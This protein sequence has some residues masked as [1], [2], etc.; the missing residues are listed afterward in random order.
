MNK[1]TTYPDVEPLSQAW[2]FAEFDEL[3]DTVGGKEY[4]VYEKIVGQSKPKRLI[5]GY[6][7]FEENVVDVKL[8]VDA[9]NE[10]RFLVELGGKCNAHSLSNAQNLYGKQMKHILNI[11]YPTLESFITGS[12]INTNNN[13]NNNNK[14]WWTDT[15]HSD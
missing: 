5:S 6:C 8:I 12:Y 14:D 9:L 15:D 1:T 10:K 11:Y 7:E 2:Y 3:P 13:N 4:C